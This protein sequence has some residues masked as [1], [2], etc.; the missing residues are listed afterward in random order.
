MRRLIAIGCA[1]LMA[2]ASNVA[3][4]APSRFVVKGDTV[5]QVSVAE[6]QSGGKMQ[7]VVGSDMVAKAP[8]GASRYSLK[9]VTWPTGTVRVLTFT[10]AGGGVKHAIT[11][12]TEFF[13]LKGSVTIVWEG[14]PTTLNEND[15]VSLPSGVVTGT[16]DATLVTWTVGSLIDSPTPKIVRAAEASVSQNAS[17]STSGVARRARSTSANTVLPFAA[18]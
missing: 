18:C 1:A 3:V 9:A 2:A 11:D 15:A 10:K 17:V 13:V 5:E 7:M 4:A 14:K 8:K 16:G 6:W 12:E